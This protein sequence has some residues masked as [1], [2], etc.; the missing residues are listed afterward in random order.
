MTVFL[1]YLFIYQCIYS[2]YLFILACCQDLVFSHEEWLTR[3]QNVLWNWWAKYLAKVRQAWIF[4]FYIQIWVYGGKK[5]RV[6]RISSRGLRRA[7]SRKPM[8]TLWNPTDWLTD[9]WKCQ[10]PSCLLCI[11]H[12]I[13]GPAEYQ[14]QPWLIPQSATSVNRIGLF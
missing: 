7:W 5:V 8:A 2:M 6:R 9:W 14:L 3:I 10:Q 4:L 1:I 12:L 11:S 13:S